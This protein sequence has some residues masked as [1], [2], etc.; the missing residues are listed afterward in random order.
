MQVLFVGNDWAEDHHDVEIVERPVGGLLV[1]DCLRG[2][3]AIGQRNRVGGGDN[4][5]VTL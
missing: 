1:G 2:Y 4:T 3:V 5:S